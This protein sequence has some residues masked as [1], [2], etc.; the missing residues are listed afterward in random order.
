MKTKRLI[1]TSLLALGFAGF[2]HAAGYQ[3]IPL[4]PNSFN[5]DVVVEA[6]YP[7][8]PYQ[9][10]VT[11]TMDSGPGSANNTWFELG[12]DMLNAT[13]AQPYGLPHPNGLATNRFLTD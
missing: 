9:N 2:A 13:T 7:N 8:L 12:A 11:V 10:A 4:T 5:Y 1:L 3:P 6:T